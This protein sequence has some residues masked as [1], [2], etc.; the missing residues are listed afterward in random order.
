M[1]AEFTHG[2]MEGEGAYN[3]HAKLQAR[4]GSLALSVLD[5]AIRNVLIDPGSSPIVIAD[6]GSSQGKNSLIPM[7]TAIS[8]FRTRIG[9]NRSILI[10][11]I[12]QPS[13]DFNSL[14]RVLDKDPE[15]YITND[16]NLYPAA[17]GKSFYQQVLPVNSVHLGW[18]SYAAMWLSRMPAFLPD[19]F[20]PICSRSAARDEFDRQAR[21]DW[22]TFLSQRAHELTLGGRLVVILPG[23]AQDGSVGLES[24]FDHANAVLAEMVADGTIG[25]EERSRMTVITH[26]RPESELLRPFESTGEFQKLLVEDCQSFPLLD[27][28]WQEY[29]LTGDQQPLIEGQAL[30]F[31][32]AF[33]PSLA[34][35]LNPSRTRNGRLNHFADQLVS[36][37][38]QRLS[39]EPSPMHSIVQTMVFAKKRE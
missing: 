4:G 35:A 19:H 13:N 24:L 21:R 39:T 33:L 31:R 3:A 11:H 18:S 28:A 10:F 26:P 23:I 9:P 17:I 20:I 32:T 8:G 5:Q 14:F 30:F 22:E 15:T 6:Y 37:L 1:S 2:V 36:R 27:S 7:G 29:E 16:A 38:K 25:S 34:C 12:D